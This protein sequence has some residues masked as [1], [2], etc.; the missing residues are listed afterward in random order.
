MFFLKCVMLLLVFISIVS[1]GKIISDKYR[2]RVTDLNE[3]K[4]A[5]NIME[6]KIKYTY[7]TIPNIF[8]EIHKNIKPQVGEIF[9]IASEKMNNKSADLSWKEAL[10]EARKNF[11]KKDDIDILYGLGN[12]LGKTNVEG[13]ISQ[14]KLTNNFLNHQIELAQAD[15]EK[16]KK[17]YKTLGVCLGLSVVVILI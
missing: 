5:L 11:L 1:I 3:I 17:L 2:K 7:E 15:E 4:Q 13:Q 14:I 16:N 6:A 9:K 12:M 8:K 10:N